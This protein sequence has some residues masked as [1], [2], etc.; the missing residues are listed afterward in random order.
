MS[1]V[2]TELKSNEESKTND[3]ILK[4]TNHSDPKVLIT[5]NKIYIFFLESKQDAQDQF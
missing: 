5:F 4:L 3:S 2:K 1:Q